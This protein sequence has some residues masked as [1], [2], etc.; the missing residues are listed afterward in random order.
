MK[1]RSRKTF[2]EEDAAFRNIPKIFWESEAAYPPDPF[3]GIAS[4]DDAVDDLEPMN[5]IEGI[6]PASG[7]GRTRTFRNRGLVILD[8]VEA[9]ERLAEAAG[10]S[11]AEF[12]EGFWT[13]LGLDI[14]EELSSREATSTR[15]HGAAIKDLTAQFGT[16]AVGTY[17][18]WHAF[19]NS[20]NSPWGIYMFFDRLVDWARYLHVSGEFFPSPKPPLITIF[21]FLWWTTFRHEL[22]HFHV[23]VFATRLESSLRIPLYRPYVERVR[24]PVTNTAEWWE[25]ALAQAVVLESRLVKRTLGIDSKYIDKY[26]IP[27]FR[28]FPEGYRRF[29]CSSVGGPEAAH[30]ILSAQIAR[31]IIS[32]REDERNTG[33]SIAKTEYSVDHRS[34]PGYLMFRPGVS[35]RFQLQ[36]PR[37]KDIERFVRRIGGEIDDHAPGDHKRIRLRGQTTHLNKARRGNGTDLASVKALARLLGISVFDLVREVG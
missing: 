4:I 6:D 15:G 9:F 27:Y 25:E 5:P 32:I 21:R 26:V 24:T 13:V 8:D 10:K 18:P 34:V 19:R 22:F 16:E 30:R 3:G 35:S 23:E 17:C 29:E 2:Q 37:L 14:E 1:P 12:V 33:L 36:T 7:D 31:T 28:T 11:D 20:A